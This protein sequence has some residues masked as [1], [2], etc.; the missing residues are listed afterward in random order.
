ML[1]GKFGKVFKKVFVIFGG[2][3]FLWMT[4]SR[5]VTMMT[6]PQ[7]Q[8]QENE[9]NQ[10]L[11][12]EQKLKE[13]AKGYKSILKNEPNNFFAL[14]ELLKIYLQLGDLQSAL[15]P[16]EKLVA[17]QPENQSYQDVLEKIKAGLA[18]QKNQSK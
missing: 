12:A 6:T 17:L 14:E 15:Q 5:M 4:T 7:D 13:S 3:A 16:A 18:Q 10:A 2:L 11:A 8:P 9:Q 1:K